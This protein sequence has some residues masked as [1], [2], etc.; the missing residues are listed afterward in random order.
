VRLFPSASARRMTE[1]A[2]GVFAPR[3]SCYVLDHIVL[4]GFLRGSF[5]ICR[6]HYVLLLK[7][8]GRWPLVF[9]AVLSFKAEES[10]CSTLPRIVG[11]IVP[12]KFCDVTLLVVIS[13]DYP[14][15][16]GYVFS[17]KSTRNT[18]RLNR[19]DSI[20]FYSRQNWCRLAI[21]WWTSQKGGSIT[22][23]RDRLM[24]AGFKTLLSHEVA[25]S[26]ESL[27]PDPYFKTKHRTA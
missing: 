8:R 20:N 18:L 23:L 7:N 15:I 17:G 4:V 11:E 6:Q 24:V 16:L 12:K 5:R 19:N 26:P 3:F 10:L 9:L 25:P 13:L 27:I 2:V 1:K 22:F 21:P 14:T